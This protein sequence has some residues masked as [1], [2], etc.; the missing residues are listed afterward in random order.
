MVQQNV[1]QSKV[2]EDM[3]SNLQTNTDQVKTLTDQ[4]GQNHGTSLGTE[5]HGYT[6]EFS[7]V[8]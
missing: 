1:Q 4:I 7:I 5:V 3:K 2:L 8:D 6:F